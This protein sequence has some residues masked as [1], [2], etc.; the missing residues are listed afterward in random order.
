M[1][2]VPMPT[3]VT[4]PDELTVHMLVVEDP[5][6]TARPELALAFNDGKLPKFCAPGSVKVMDWLAAG[7]TELDAADAEP[8]PADVV[9]DTVKV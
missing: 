7:A 1:V 3:K 4:I 9:A 6:L 2:Q 8:V 5:K